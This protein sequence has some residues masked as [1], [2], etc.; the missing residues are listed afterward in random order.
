MNESNTPVPEWNGELTLVVETGG[1]SFSTACIESVTISESFGKV[2]LAVLTLVDSEESD[3][4]ISDSDAFTPGQMVSVSAGYDDSKALLFK[5]VVVRQGI[6]LVTGEPKLIVTVKHEAFRMSLSRRTERYADSKDSDVVKDLVGRYGLQADI[7]DTMV[8]HESMVQYNAS[9]WDFINMR[10]EANGQLLATTPE[11]VV[12]HKPDLSSEPVLLLDGG[13]SIIDMEAELDGMS[14]FDGFK[15]SSWN[16]TSQ[17]NDDVEASAGPDS[18]QGSLKTGDLASAMGN[19]DKLVPSTGQQANA[20]GLTARV[21]AEAAFSS[22]RRITGQVTI[23]GSIPVHPGCLVSLKNVGGRI[24]GDAFVTAVAHDIA[25]GIWHTRLRFGLDEPRYCDRYDDISAKPAMGVF[26][27]ISCLFL[28][29]VSQLKDDPLGEYRIQIRLLNGDDT[30][31]WARVALLDA[32][33]GRGSEFLPEIDD[34][35]VVGFVDDD[36]NQAVVLGM[37][38]S[39]A[40]PSPVDPDDDNNIK[41][42]YTREKIK[43]EFDDEKKSFVVQTPGGNSISLSDDAKSINIEDQNGNKIK[44]DG[45]GITIES[46]KA[47]TFSAKQ[48]VT[49]KGT[50]VS[51]EAN[52]SLK[53]NGNASAELKANGNVVVKGAVVQIN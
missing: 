26:P 19:G 11:G 48:D 41:G 32:G 34:E 17:A 37:L 33:N 36:P 51:V 31:L 43:M 27:A 14:A 7:E 25:G 20:D 45:N 38:H 28:A 12:S 1:K 3:F 9:D 13:Y 39:S 47:L 8:T 24:G 29:K 23:P 42:I 52:A 15:S 50:N 44:L 22:L 16:F 4:D 30:T 49:I 5:G 46:A 6:K 53:A 18:P 40:S 2:A 21:D 35:V 10:T